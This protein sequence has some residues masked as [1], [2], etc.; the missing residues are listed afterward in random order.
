MGFCKYNA[1]YQKDREFHQL[2]DL[3]TR[4]VVDEFY[5]SQCRTYIFL[6]NPDQIF[7]IIE[8]VLPVIFSLKRTKIVIERK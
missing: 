4:N 5:F 2:E 7:Q 3:K 6:K 1:D 8:Q